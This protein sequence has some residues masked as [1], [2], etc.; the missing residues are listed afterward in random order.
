[1]PPPAVRQRG[2][3]AV[4]E[5]SASIEWSEEVRSSGEGPLSALGTAGSHGGIVS[6]AW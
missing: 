5:V 2:C 1:M 6:G 3:C 4:S